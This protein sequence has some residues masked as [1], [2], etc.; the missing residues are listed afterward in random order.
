[1]S[2]VIAQ[3]DSRRSSLKWFSGSPSF[4]HT[5]YSGLRLAKSS[6]VVGA[7]AVVVAVGVAARK[8]VALHKDTTLSPN[9]PV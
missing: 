3:K 7:V 4:S 6:F 5:I 2:L 1:M 8:V 9:W